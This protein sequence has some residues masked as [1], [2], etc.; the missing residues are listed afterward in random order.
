MSPF[1][2]IYLS[3]CAIRKTASLQAHRHKN[4]CASKWGERLNS[5]QVK[6]T[7]EEKL[8]NEGTPKGET[9]YLKVWGIE[10]TATFHHQNPNMQLF[11]KEKEKKKENPRT[12]SICFSVWRVG[13]EIKQ[14]FD[15]SF[16][17][18]RNHALG[19]RRWGASSSYVHCLSS[20]QCVHKPQWS[21]HQNTYSAH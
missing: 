4:S 19:R 14:V 20:F 18:K 17:D 11:R 12:V 8:G 6:Q 10:Q 9:E 7:W 5:E 2:L 15:I 13:G 3:V 21:F 1:H 16:I